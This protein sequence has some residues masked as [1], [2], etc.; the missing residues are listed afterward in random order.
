MD[1]CENAAM[2][3]QT[4]VIPGYQAFPM[5]SI[6]LMKRELVISSDALPLVTL[7]SCSSGT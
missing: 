5:R 3:T 1:S 7:G 2:A 6:S 4:V